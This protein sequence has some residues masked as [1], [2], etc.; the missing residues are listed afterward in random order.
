M[1]IEIKNYTQAV[2]T[3]SSYLAERS[4]FALVDTQIKGEGREALYQYTAGEP[5]TPKTLRVGWYPN[6]KANDG[7]GQVNL[8]VKITTSAVVTI[9]EQ[10]KVLPVTA[11]LAL[12]VPGNNV[13]PDTDIMQGL[14]Q[15]LS[16]WLTPVTAGVGQ[17]DIWNELSHGIV[18]DLLDH[19][20][21]GEA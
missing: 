14:A 1:T 12:S 6:P 2:A 9:G 19:T 11:T 20:D 3:I 4:N 10:T 17:P 21:T 5:E 8:S 7:Y 18:N 15:E 16:S 13:A